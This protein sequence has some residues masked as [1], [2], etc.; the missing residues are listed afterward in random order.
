MTSR[1]AASLLLAS[2]CLVTGLSTSTARAEQPSP[3]DLWPQATSAANAGDLDAAIKQTSGLIDTGK[4]YGVKTFP[5]Y[6]ASAAALARQADK[7][8]NKPVAQWAAKAADQ[9]DPGSA[10]VAFSNA[11]RAADQKQ[12]GKAAAY[13]AT[14]FA[15]TVIGYRSRLLSRADTLMVLLLAIA[16]TSIIF[17]ASL[18]IRYFRAMGHD[19]RENLSQRFRGGSI[20]VLAFALLFLPI[21]LWLGPFW[22]VFYWFIIFFGYAKPAERV[23]IVVLSLL[24]ALS[25][26]ALDLSAHWIAGS[27]NPAVVAAV[28]SAEQSYQ[29][30]ALR[31]MQDLVSIVP[32]SPRLQLL[33]G[34]LLM[35]EGNERQA[36]EHYR[37]SAELKDSAGAHVNLG[38]LHYLDNDFAAAVTEYEKAE[39][40]DPRLAI[41]F[42]NHSLASGET[43]KFDEQAKMLETA[44]RLDR[45]TVEKLS[46]AP[47]AQKVVMYHL[48]VREAWTIAASVARG[49]AARSLFGNYSYFDPMV[50]SVNPLTIGAILALAL[51]LIF[52]LR[53]RRSG[54]AGSCIKCGRTFCHRC[55]SARESATYCTQCIHIYLK[56]DGVSLDTKRTKLEEVQDH[57][58]G[59]LRRNRIFATLLPGTG[60][61]LEGRTI[62]GIIGL[63]LF[64]VFVCLA[65]L[66]GRLAPVLASGEVATLLVRALAVLA[67]VITWFTLAMPVWRRRAS[68][69]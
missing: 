21:F 64:L 18:F 57:Q 3:R 62:A 24:L 61:L 14:G 31:R 58:S 36:A 55:K 53:R 33:L 8:N 60:Q 2:L 12:Y 20:S 19:F 52:W 1:F 9:L 35:F 48:P 41:T 38:N 63:F 67:A 17:A 68:T 11:D 50:S 29:P 13:V 47:P 51:A 44:R 5:L 37:R 16:L 10:A 49:G 28:G 27:D 26:I 59:M 56:R 15:R 32:D 30:D 22:L 40:L 34:N 54:F 66:V 45:A 7:E 25:P 43:Y 4:S 69:V 23:L 42:Y 65:L 6:A 46:S 39:A